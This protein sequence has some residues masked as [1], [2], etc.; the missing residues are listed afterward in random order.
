[1]VKWN[2][3][4]NFDSII[5]NDTYNGIVIQIPMLC[6][7]SFLYIAFISRESGVYD[8]MLLLEKDSQSIT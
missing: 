7:I 2:L 4:P 1:M 3:A 6:L 8:N 5:V